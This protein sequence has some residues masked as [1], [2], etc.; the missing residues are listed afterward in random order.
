MSDVAPSRDLDARSCYRT[1]ELALV[2]CSGRAL[3]RSGLPARP[4]PET[5]P[6]PATSSTRR[7]A[8]DLR[9]I[10][11]VNVDGTID[12]SSLS[13]DGAIHVLKA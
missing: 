10:G 1:L 4:L 3:I 11:D 9:A 2:K 5:D 12:F 13:G 7:S 8:R 6:Q